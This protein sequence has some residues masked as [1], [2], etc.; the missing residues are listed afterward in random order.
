ML[1]VLTLTFDILTINETIYKQWEEIVKSANTKV[2]VASGLAGAA[3]MSTLLA[4]IY[5]NIGIIGGSSTGAAAAGAAGVAGA[6]ATGAAAAGA[7]GAA[8]A[9]AAG[10]AAAGATGAAAAGAAAAAGTTVVVGAEVVAGAGIAASTATATAT[11]GAAGATLASAMSSSVV[12]GPLAL[13]VVSAGL[14]AMHLHFRKKANNQAED[15]RKR[16]SP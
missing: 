16:E 3:S 1:N 4:S 11:T 9:G 10:T 15:L 12:L 7:A 2:L 13:F 5:L 14:L 8:A 6:G